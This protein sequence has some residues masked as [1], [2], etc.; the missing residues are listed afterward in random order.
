[1]KSVVLR[2]T[3]LDVQDKIGSS[4]DGPA[5]PGFCPKPQSIGTK[6]SFRQGF[7]LGFRQ[8][9]DDGDPDKK[10]A[11]HGNAGVTERQGRIVCGRKTGEQ[12]GQAGQHQGTAGG[13]VPS[14]IVTERDAG[15]PE[16]GRKQFREINRVTAEH[17]HQEKGH[18][19]NQYEQRR[20]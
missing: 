16:P 20:G 10:H 11:A 17:R 8:Q 3:V 18:Q 9:P 15:T 14:G 6:K 19:G 7:P 12:T 1:M 4:V 5:A 2:S 13:D